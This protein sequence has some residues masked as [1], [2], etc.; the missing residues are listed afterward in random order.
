LTENLYSASAMKDNLYLG[1]DVGSVSVK[2]ALLS[3][4]GDILRS[5]YRRSN[6]Q[7]LSTLR[8]ILQDLFQE[9][10]LEDV[11][12]LAATGTGGKLINSILS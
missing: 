4:D 1:I 12:S 7:P 6:G 2:A 10:H 11:K 8:G 9:F 3:L 5:C